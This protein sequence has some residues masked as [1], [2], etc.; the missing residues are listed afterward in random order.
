MAELFGTVTGRRAYQDDQI[1]LAELATRQQTAAAQI[2]L[3][4]AQATNLEVDNAR[5]AEVVA[6]A[7]RKAA[8]EAALRAEL[9]RIAQGGQPNDGTAGKPVLGGGTQFDSLLAT[10][11]AQARYLM[12]VG[13][14]EEATK[15]LAPLTGGVK[16]LAQARQ[17]VSAAKENDLDVQS[18]RHEL[19]ARIMSGATDPASYQAA[20]MQLQASGVMTPE[21]LAEVPRQ[22]NPRFVKSVLAGSAAA[23][24]KAD[25]EK[26]AARTAAQT[27]ND[28]DQIKNR[29]LARDLEERKLSLSREREARLAKQGEGGLR[30]DDKPLSPAS[31]RELEMVRSELKR[32]GIKVG[33]AQG[34]LVADIAEQVKTLVDGNPGLSRS[35]ASAR[36]VA[37]MKERGELEVR[38]F[39]SDKYE[40]KQ[41]SVTMPLP[42]PRSAAELKKGNYYLDAEDGLVKLFD[43]KGFIVSTRRRRS[44]ARQAQEEE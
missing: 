44:D 6:M 30:A 35:E 8:D 42:T 25:M 32:T 28:Y 10:G 33:D 14:V 39:R 11:E 13:R 3:A 21:D 23:K 17:A 5:Q 34:A 7:Q 41:G 4:N 16:D 36:I 26:D 20:V 9:A 43:G 31:V 22:Y 24:Q 18:K 1:K 38:S 37:E 15:L 27:A 19:V 12:S 2:K 29:R 40:P